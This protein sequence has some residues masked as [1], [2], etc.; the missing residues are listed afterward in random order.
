MTLSALI[1]LTVFLIIAG[2]VIGALYWI[3]KT[4]PMPEPIRSWAAWAVLALGLL[5]IVVRLLALSGIAT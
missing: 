5:I 2:L 1:A 3:V 4:S